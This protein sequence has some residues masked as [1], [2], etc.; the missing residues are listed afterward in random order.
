TTRHRLPAALPSRR[1]PAPRP[2]AR[3][4]TRARRTCRAAERP[5]RRRL[6][7]LRRVRR[8]DRR[9]ARGA[10][11]RLGD[12]DLEVEQVP[13]RL[14][15]DGLGHRLEELVALALVLDQRVALRHRAQPDALLE[16]VHLVEV[17]A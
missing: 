9:L 1:S 14:L 6:R 13:D 2:E 5:A 12:L 10:R 16:V 3:G 7:G 4:G 17:L 11:A 15:L 8:G